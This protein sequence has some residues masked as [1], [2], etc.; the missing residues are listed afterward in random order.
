[1]T[2]HHHDPA[3]SLTSDNGCPAQVFGTVLP[4]AGLDPVGPA[5]A[6][7]RWWFVVPVLNRGEHILV[8]ARARWAALR[9]GACVLGEGVGLWC[10]RAT[11]A[12]VLAEGL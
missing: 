7:M 5:V 1:M 8:L 3:P 9:L 10:R 12:E 11:D 2:H 6:P 4:A